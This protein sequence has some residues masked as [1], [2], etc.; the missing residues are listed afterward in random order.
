MAFKKPPVIILAYKNAGFSIPIQ[1][2]MYVIITQSIT[3][4]YV[5]K[6]N[7]NQTI[8]KKINGRLM[9]HANRCLRKGK[10]LDTLILPNLQSCNVINPVTCTLT[11]NINNR[12]SS[13]TMSCAL[14][15][16]C[17]L[18]TCIQCS[19][20][21]ALGSSVQFP[22]FSVG[23][24]LKKQGNFEKMASTSIAQNYFTFV[25]YYTAAMATP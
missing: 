17:Q 16:S 21:P 14:C 18:A 2:R 22:G 6:N 7:N 15:T 11:T 25:W 24:I 4:Q 12:K 8:V 1:T 19:L 3:T 13:H 23:C 20:M 5:I 10:S 9:L